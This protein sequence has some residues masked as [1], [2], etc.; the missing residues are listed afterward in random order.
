MEEKWE[1]GDAGKNN[2]RSHESPIHSV[3]LLESPLKIGGET[4]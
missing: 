2:I 3:N 4:G 1:V